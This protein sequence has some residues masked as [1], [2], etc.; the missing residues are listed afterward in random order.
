[1]IELTNLRKLISKTTESEKGDGETGMKE[2][3][4]KALKCQRLEDDNH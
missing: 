2:E 4:K 1:L 3:M